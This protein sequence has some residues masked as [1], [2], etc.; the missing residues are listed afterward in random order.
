MR[1]NTEH[2]RKYLCADLPSGRTHPPAGLSWFI[3]GVG[4]VLYAIGFFMRT[5]PAVMTKDLMVT[6]NIAATELGQLASFFFY[7]Y[8]LMQLP[9]GML[10]RLFGPRKLLTVGAFATAIGTFSFAASSNFYLASI[11][12]LL[13]G[14]AVGMAIVLTLELSGRWLPKHKFALASGLTMVIGVAGAFLAGVPLSLLI[15]M[16]GWRNCMLALSV[17][18]LAIGIVSWVVVRDNPSEKGF[19]DYKASNTITKKDSKTLGLLVSL[20]DALSYRNTWLMLLIPSGLIGAMLSF[21]GLWGV[22]YLKVRFNLSVEQAA[23]ICSGMLIAFALCSPIIGHVSDRQ[24]RRKP[25]Y[26]IGVVSATI[27]W[28]VVILLDGLPLWAMVSLLIIAAGFTGAM[29]LSYALGRESAS[30]ENSDI[31]TGLVVTGIMIGPAIIQPVTGWLVDLQ[32]NGVME[33][34]IRVYNEAAFKVAFLP[35]L[36]WL[37]LATMIVPLVKETYCGEKSFIKE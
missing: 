36:G 33:A 23:M 37:I 5:A 22:P 9:T 20:S 8:V 15:S 11:G 25:V 24:K 18:T 2:S 7:A 6:F 16:F 27:C 30:T 31:V 4:A 19:Q 35:M 34:G 28:L 26:V 3:W 32:W 12:L 1:E 10:S 17:F 14:G 29:P 13:V 21:T